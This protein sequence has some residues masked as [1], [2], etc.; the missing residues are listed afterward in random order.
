MDWCFESICSPDGAAITTLAE[1]S[2]E[3]RTAMVE[4]FN[5]GNFTNLDLLVFVGIGR[6]LPEENV[7]HLTP[8]SVHIAGPFGVAADSMS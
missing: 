6:R 2:K 8:R 4:A 5:I 7:R 3:I 1:K